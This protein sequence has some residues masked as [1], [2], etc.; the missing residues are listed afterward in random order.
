[1]S[2]K[3]RHW[4]GVLAMTMVVAL[5]PSTAAAAPTI[6]PV[7]SGLDSPRGIAF[8]HGSLMVGEAGHGE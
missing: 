5:L 7:T 8:L 2:L 4:F 3:K 6:T 1:M